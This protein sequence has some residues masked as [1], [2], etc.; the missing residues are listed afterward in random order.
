MGRK[1][2]PYIYVYAVL[3]SR[4]GISTVGNAFI[5]SASGECLGR[6]EGFRKESPDKGNIPVGKEENL[7]NETDLEGTGGIGAS[8]GKVGTAGGIGPYVRTGAVGGQD[9]A[10]GGTGSADGSRSSGGCMPGQAVDILPVRN[11][12]RDIIADALS[13]DADS[14]DEG[15]SLGDMEPDS[16]SIYAIK[17]DLEDMLKIHVSLDELQG[18]QPLGEW[19]D[20]ILKDYGYSRD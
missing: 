13:L 18:N 9:R 17:A 5:Y 20:M 8:G 11:K 3:E 19:M 1:K 12:I 6:I 15:Q 10:A 14:L 2:G 4:T 7:G 16:L